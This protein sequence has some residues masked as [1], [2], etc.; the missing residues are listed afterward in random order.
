MKKDSETA[1]MITS[2]IDQ[3]YPDFMNI[4]DKEAIVLPMYNED[5]NIFFFSNKVFKQFKGPQENDTLIIKNVLDKL[6]YMLK[7]PGDI[8]MKG[9]AVADANK[10]RHPSA[11]NIAM[12]R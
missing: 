12:Y 10:N 9:R 7:L 6:K 2:P 4:V 8:M 11:K 1:C 3:R 5:I